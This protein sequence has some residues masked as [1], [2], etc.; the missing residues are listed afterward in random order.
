MGERCTISGHIQEAWY[1]RGAE[2]DQ[3]LLLASN[4]RVIESLPVT[5]EWPFLVRRMFRFSTSGN[6][7]H[8]TGTSYRGR[9][10]FFGGSFSKLY[11]DW[12]VWLEKFE[13]LLR[14][15]YWEHAV[16]VHVTELMGTF[17]HHWKATRGAIERLSE[18]PPVPIQ[19]WRYTGGLRTFKDA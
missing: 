13:N 8:H 19:E 11:L 3:R 10:I 7:F 18:K 2:Q 5:D 15:L 9:V 14:Q 4:R 16:V 1:F 17:T 6:S 12:D